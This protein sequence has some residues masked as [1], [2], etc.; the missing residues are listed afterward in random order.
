M[1][2]AP[3]VSAAIIFLWGERWILPCKGL[4]LL[5]PGVLINFPFIS[6]GAQGDAGIGAFQGHI[7]AVCVIAGE[8]EE[9]GNPIGAIAVF[10]AHQQVDGQL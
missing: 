3:G 2:A 10:Q 6:V 5:L 1:K 7:V 8:F 9:L 4:Y